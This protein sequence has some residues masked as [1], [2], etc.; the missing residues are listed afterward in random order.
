MQTSLMVMASTF[1]GQPPQSSGL[2]AAAPVSGPS[3]TS[4]RR[5]GDSAS[6]CLRRV[7]RNSALHSAQA[8]SDHLDI[9]DGDGLNPGGFH[10]S[11]WGDFFLHHSNPADFE[12]QQCLSIIQYARLLE[13]CFEQA[14]MLKRAEVLKEEVRSIISRSITLSLHQ[15][16][17]LIETIERLCL[18]YLF[19][20][21]ISI[22]L[23]E[24]S[25]ADVND[26][27]LQ[28]VALWFYLLRKHGYR[29]SSGKDDPISNIWTYMQY[30]CANDLPECMKFALRKIFYSYHIIEDE[31]ANM[32]RYRMMYLRNFTLDLVRCFNAEVKMRE[33]GYVPKSVEEHLQVSLRSGGCHLLSC[34]SLVGM[35]DIATKDSFDWISSMPKMVTR[36]C[37]IL[38]LLDDLQTYERERKMTLH[39]AS[40]I[41][42][43]MKEHNVSIEIAREK[44]VELKEETWKDFNAEWLNPENSQPKQI[45]NRIFN[46]ARTMEFFYNKDDNFTN[47]HNIKDKIHSLFVEPFTIM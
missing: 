16:L 21:E 26:C 24:A 34:A 12:E 30:L 1:P 7:Q 43:Y 25:T 8:R 27:D 11:I 33:D 46:L 18:D 47:C 4:W 37:I 17:H 38:R 15:R 19:E 32:E 9:I 5:R 31:L 39:V 6:R 14:W 13:Y 36:L 23:A 10:P 44:V 42:S 41:D 20:E 40:T 29:V 28:T 35:D 45:L 3:V 2:S 22:A